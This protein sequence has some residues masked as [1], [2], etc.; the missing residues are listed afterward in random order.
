LPRIGC[1]CRI[2]PYSSNEALANAVDSVLPH[3]PDSHRHA[4][5]ATHDSLAA[6]ALYRFDIRI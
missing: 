3:V 2:R 5:I 4:L 6:G 1:R